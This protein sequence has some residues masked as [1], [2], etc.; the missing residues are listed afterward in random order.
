VAGQ[1]G[2]DFERGRLDKTH[3][4]F[5]TRFSTGDVRI[6]T[7]LDPHDIGESL[8][9]II[10]EAGHALYEQGVAAGLDGTPLG[11]LGGTYSNLLSTLKPAQGR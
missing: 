8:F 1:I 10:H 3:H 7:R 2:Y 9:S 11:K 4:P 5:A 6:T